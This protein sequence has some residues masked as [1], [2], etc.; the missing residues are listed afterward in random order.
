MVCVFVSIVYCLVSLGLS[1]WTKFAD[2]FDHK[3]KI[4]KKTGPALLNH[5]KLSLAHS[6]LELFLESE[7]YGHRDKLLLSKTKPHQN[8]KKKFNCF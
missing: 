8:S 1:P 3:K 6:I 2:R 7:T 4:K 5:H